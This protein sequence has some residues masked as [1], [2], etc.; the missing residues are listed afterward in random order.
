[1][2]VPTLVTPRTNP[3]QPRQNYVQGGQ[4]SSPDLGSSLVQLSQLIDQRQQKREAFDVSKRVIEETNALQMD[5]SEREKAEPLGAKGFTQRIND[6]YTARHQDILE[7]Y[8]EMGY[9]KESLREL[10]T[11]LSALRQSFTG[12]ALNFQ[13]NSFK[14][15]ADKE[16]KDLTVSLS[17]Y[18]T[19]NPAGI[20]SA[21]TELQVA[22]KNL[23]GLEDTDAQQLYDHYSSVI[24]QGAGEGLALY[25]PQSVVDL[26]APEEITT[27][28]I[29]TP[30]GRFDVDSY[31]AAN[32][33][34]ESSGDDGATAT[35]SSAVG[36][37][38]FLKGTWLEYYKKA[39]LTLAK[40]TS[41]FWLNVP[42]VTFRIK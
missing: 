39:I 16:L 18:A 6:D 7:S 20:E 3:A 26:L 14:G 24:L 17:Q 29:D 11:R 1:M 31:M 15:L 2:R 23:D 10:D 9:S 8:R 38:Q 37:Y 36:R 35:T 13:Y 5:Y 12:R 28:V 30:T 32:R 19:N 4:F 42:K 27:T 41:R 33:S 34:A 21:L 22:I 25:N 40:L